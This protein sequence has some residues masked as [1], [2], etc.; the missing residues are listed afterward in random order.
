MTDR[1]RPMPL[2][3]SWDERRSMTDVQTDFKGIYQ[4]HRL[5][6]Y[7]YVL[8][9]VGSVE[10]A[11]DITAQVFLKAYQKRADYSGKAPVIYWLLAIARRELA[12]HYRGGSPCTVLEDD[13]LADA[14][15]PPEVIAEQNSLLIRVSKALQ[16]LS[17]DRREAI[18]LRF[19]VGL[20]NPEIAEWMGKSGDA[21]AML[22]YRG[23][24]DLRTRLGSL[25]ELE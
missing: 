17:E 7:R 8:L 10:D 13:R 4:H 2:W 9:R 25:E 6:I 18:T 21:V 23:I 1:E 5:A 14:A 20:S 3:M 11:E 16:A 19:F 24:Q 22:V 15:P 12:D